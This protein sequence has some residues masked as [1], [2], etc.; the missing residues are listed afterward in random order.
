MVVKKARRE[1][2]R[3]VTALLVAA[4]LSIPSVGWTI[5]DQT[6]LCGPP[7]AVETSIAGVSASGSAIVANVCPDL[8]CLMW[9]IPKTK[10]CRPAKR[11][12]A[13]DRPPFFRSCGIVKRVVTRGAVTRRGGSR[14]SLCNPHRRCF[15]RGFV[16]G[17][18]C[19]WGSNSPDPH[20]RM[21]A[22]ASVSQ[23]SPKTCGDDQGSTLAVQ[24]MPPTHQSKGHGAS[25]AGCDET[26][27]N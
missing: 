9:G 16:E 3:R 12:L 6:P 24:H 22:L 18:D 21:T 15:H 4:H 25:V 11:S 7:P 27:T 8:V 17:D 23:G 26:I 10:S 13:P 2:P 5:W 20:V 19:R 14:R 1:P